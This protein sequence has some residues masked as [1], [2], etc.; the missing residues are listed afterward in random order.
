MASSSVVA[1][2]SSGGVQDKTLMLEQQL[3]ALHR[4][5]GRSFRSY[6]IEKFANLLLFDGN[7]I[8]IMIVA[9]LR[10]LI[11]STYFEE[12]S[13]SLL[14]ALLPLAYRAC[15]RLLKDRELRSNNPDEQSMIDS[16]KT[17]GETEIMRSFK[18]P[19]AHLGPI[20]NAYVA[21]IT[22]LGPT[23]LFRLLFKLSKLGYGLRKLQ[24]FSEPSADSFNVHGLYFHVVHIHQISSSK[25]VGKLIRM[26]IDRR[27]SR[28]R[29]MANKRLLGEKEKEFSPLTFASAAELALA[30]LAFGSHSHSRG[31]P[32]IQHN[33]RSFALAKKEVVVC[34]GN[35][36][37]A[38]GRTGEWMLCRSYAKIAVDFCD[39]V[40]DDE[41]KLIGWDVASLKAKNQRR[42]TYAS[43]QLK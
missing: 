6:A 8:A 15:Q 14:L 2:A 32:A 26:S 38:A 16:K 34:V 24:N 40:S 19:V 22:I 37:E 11:N 21:P 43:S 36:S 5:R 7:T 29:E 42:Y 12:A 41:A 18:P 9:Q 20:V 3:I 13:D 31:L 33:Q 17:I 39:T 10:L 23:L 4:N 30:Q 35:A 25:V 27:I 28:H 1:G